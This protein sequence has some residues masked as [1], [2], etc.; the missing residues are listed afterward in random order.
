MDI[1]SIYND[2]RIGLVI[3]IVKCR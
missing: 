3:I 1:I 2:N